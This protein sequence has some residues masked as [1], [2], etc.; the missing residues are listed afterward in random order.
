M[1]GLRSNLCCRQICWAFEKYQGNMCNIPLRVSLRDLFLFRFL[2]L[3][4]FY[5]SQLRL[6]FF[7]VSKLVM[8]G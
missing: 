2:F 6:I 5:F 3:Y 4:S 8:A 7:D 1:L